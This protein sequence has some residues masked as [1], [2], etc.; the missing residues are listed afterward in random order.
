MKNQ[1][2]TLYRAGAIAPLVAL[3]CYLSQ[4]LILAFF[5]PF[6]TDIEGWFTLFQHSKLLGLWYLN[7]LDILSIALL[8][9]LFLALYKALKDASP[10]WMVI[11]L[12]LALLGVVVFVVPR[13][14]T[15][16]VA[17]LSD[18]YAAAT[19][20]AQRTLFLAAGEALSSL[21][22]ATP[23]TL[24]FLF[25]AAAGLI[26]SAINLRS[27]VFGRAASYLGIAAF[28]VALANYVTWLLVPSVTGFLAPINGLL[29]LVWW[30]MMSFGLVKLARA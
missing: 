10:S 11:A 7:A 18:R 28:V 26:V 16:S 1:W 15:L 21:I 2:T 13:A 20:E 17:V 19:N 8:G 23:Q 22:T 14:L 4:F 5:P 12:Y 29:W 27:L 3:I 9:T 24:G 6:P 25:M 30:L